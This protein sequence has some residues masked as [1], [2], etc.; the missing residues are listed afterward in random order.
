MHSLRISFTLAC[1]E[2]S[3]GHLFVLVFVITNDIDCPAHASFE[4]CSLFALHV[5][6]NIIPS[7]H[8]D[9]HRAQWS[10]LEKSSATFSNS[11]AVVSINESQYLHSL[12]GRVVLF[13]GATVRSQLLN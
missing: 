10:H 5:Q 7:L 3:A 12:L 1:A 13:T 9:I 6:Y 4:D 2:D 11:A 8:V